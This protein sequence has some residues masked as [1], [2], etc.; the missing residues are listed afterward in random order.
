MGGFRFDV[1]AEYWPL[2]AEG[3]GMTLELTVLCVICGVFLGMLLGRRPG[4]TRGNR[5]CTT[6]CAGP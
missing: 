3:I 5:F 4:T 2:F 6:A 1:L